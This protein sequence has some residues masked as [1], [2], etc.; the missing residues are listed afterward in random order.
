[1]FAWTKLFLDLFQNSPSDTIVQTLNRIIVKGKFKND[2]KIVDITESIFSKVTNILS[3]NYQSISRFTKGST[4]DFKHVENSTVQK[5]ITNDT[6]WDNESKK[7]IINYAVRLIQDYNFKSLMRNISLLDE[8]WR[9]YNWY[10]GY[11]KIEPPYWGQ[12]KSLGTTCKAS[13][14]SDYRLRFFVYTTKTFGSMSTK[15]FGN[16]FD[17][18]K[19]ERDYKISFYFYPPKNIQNSVYDYHF[20]I[21]RNNLT[22]YEEFYDTVENDISILTRK[23]SPPGTKKRFIY[24]MKISKD[25]L[26]N[27]QANLMPGFKLKWFFTHY[28]YP[29]IMQPLNDDIDTTYFTEILNYQFKRFVNLVKFSGMEINY[30]WD[31][32]ISWKLE[33]IIDNINTLKSQSCF[34]KDNY[35]LDQTE[36]EYKMDLFEKQLGKAIL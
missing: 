28:N 8:E 35:V 5:D 22:E 23:I 25:D 18:D 17:A 21:E 7:E 15:Y 24:S 20:Q 13:K 29:S 32:V 2:R 36:V 11:T 4:N 33:Y 16:N 27:V 26:K 34:Q 19:I 31:L 12:S 3:L 10:M 6:T 1:M 30:I 14:C 9:Y